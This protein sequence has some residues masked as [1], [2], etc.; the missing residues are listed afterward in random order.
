MDDLNYGYRLGETTRKKDFK[1]P[2]ERLIYKNDFIPPTSS[3]T[4]SDGTTPINSLPKPTPN[5]SL[6]IAPKEPPIKDDIEQIFYLVKKYVKEPI[7]DQIIRSYVMKYKYLGGTDT[8]NKEKI[9]NLLKEVSS[10]HSNKLNTPSFDIDSGDWYEDK[11]KIIIRSDERNI[12]K[13]PQPTDF[14]ISLFPPNGISKVK[15]FKLLSCI[16]P[17]HSNEDNLNINDFP[18]LILQI[19]EIGP[20]F[21]S[22]NGKISGFCPLTFETD[23]GQF[24]IFHGENS[25]F[26]TKSIF[27]SKNITG[28]SISFCLPNGDPFLFSP[29]NTNSTPKKKINTAE[30]EYNPDPFTSNNSKSFMDITGDSEGT[31]DNYPVITLLFEITHLKKRE[32]FTSLY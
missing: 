25:S 27:P 23:T 4:S 21:L 28:L 19:K 13:Y 31:T 16:F 20:Q 29:I 18:Y 8:W 3:P 24:K 15:E 6:S 9:T 10:Y 11:I 12:I 30:M 22:K 5:I 2:E 7:P 1:I 26:T 17:K 14:F 32:N